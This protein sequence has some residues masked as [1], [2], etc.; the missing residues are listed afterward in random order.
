MYDR[1]GTVIP[2]VGCAQLESLD[3]SFCG[4]AVNDDMLRLLAEGLPKL[5]KLSVR[6]ALISWHGDRAAARKKKER[7]PGLFPESR[8]G[9]ML[10]QRL[11]LGERSRPGAPRQQHTTAV[12]AK[13]VVLVRFRIW[14]WVY[15][16]S[17]Y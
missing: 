10:S 6:Y 12:Y 7:K 8:V 14:R 3:L 4:S 16:S 17:S 2:V 15:T 1:A 9:C 11:R 13:R 5:R